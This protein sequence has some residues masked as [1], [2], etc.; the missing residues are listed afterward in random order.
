MI[1]MSGASIDFV[2]GKFSCNSLLNRLLLECGLTA[3]CYDFLEMK[4]DL[5][6]MEH[7]ALVEPKDSVII[8]EV[9]SFEGFSVQVE[10]QKLLNYDFKGK[11]CCNSLLN[12]QSLECD[13]D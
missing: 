6:Q 3:K 10:K 2:K 13:R 4:H 1:K 7:T 12:R 5:L 9:K 8:W 11:F